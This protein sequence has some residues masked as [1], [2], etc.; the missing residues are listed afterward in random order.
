[1]WLLLGFH[2]RLISVFGNAEFKLIVM[3]SLYSIFSGINILR[4]CK[5]KL[6]CSLNDR[7]D[8]CTVCHMLEYILR[9]KISNFLSK[10]IAD[11]SY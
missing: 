8:L 5:L 4:S 11:Q 1:M 2:I 9:D 7:A 6:H 3:C 10:V